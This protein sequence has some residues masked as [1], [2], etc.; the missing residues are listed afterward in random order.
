MDKKRKIRTFLL[1]FA[2][3]FLATKLLGLHVFTH[4]SDVSTTDQCE[5]CHVVSAD[6]QHSA[7]VE[8]PSADFQPLPNFNLSKEVHT[9]YA[10]AYSDDA[11]EYNLFSRPPPMI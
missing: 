8:E 5:I 6:L 10:F 7:K 1:L 2:G 11:L 3:L 9:S 4:E